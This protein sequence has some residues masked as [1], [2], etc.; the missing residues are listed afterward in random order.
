M[1]RRTMVRIGA[2]LGGLTMVLSMGV[3]AGQRLAADMT[4]TEAFRSLPPSPDGIAWVACHA[5]LE[6]RSSTEAINHPQ[7]FCQ[8]VAEE[9]CGGPA[10][11]L[12]H[13]GNARE[14]NRFRERFRC[15]SSLQEIMDDSLDHATAGT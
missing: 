13:G 8:H 5:T 6:A 11:F 12:D 1:Q 2:T 15:G 4:R 10:T 7:A 3:L 9:V 14:A